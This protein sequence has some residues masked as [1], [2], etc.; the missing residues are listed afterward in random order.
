M[1]LT[2]VVNRPADRN[3]PIAHVCPCKEPRNRL[4]KLDK[5]RHR[6]LMPDTGEQ[7]QRLR[8][9][10]GRPGDERQGREKLLA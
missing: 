2:V 6:V 3:P 7:H 9:L 8:L 5:V 10:G 4:S 1:K